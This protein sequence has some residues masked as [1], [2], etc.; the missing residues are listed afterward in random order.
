M[1]S[2]IGI[3][4]LGAWPQAGQAG[5]ATCPE[6]GIVPCGTGTTA[7][8]ERTLQIRIVVVVVVVV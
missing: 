4:H 5:S 2:Q 8:A 6:V 7:A 1:A 3:S